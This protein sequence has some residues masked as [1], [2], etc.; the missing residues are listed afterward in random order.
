M[1]KKYVKPMIM[2]ESIALNHS[3][4]S[5]GDNR[6]IDKTNMNQDICSFTVESDFGVPVN[7]FNNGNKNCLEF[8]GYCY[9]TGSTDGI[10]IFGS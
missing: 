1:K 6:V 4:S 8:E 7:P 2:F 5:C 10:T 3:I 9:T